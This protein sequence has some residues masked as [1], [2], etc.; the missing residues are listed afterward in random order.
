MLRDILIG[1]TVRIPF[2]P[3]ALPWPNIFIPALL[4]GI[5]R[6]SRFS[7]SLSGYPT[8][9]SL[10]PPAPRPPSTPNATPKMPMK[11]FSKNLNGARKCQGSKNPRRNRWHPHTL[12][13]PDFGP[14]IKLPVTVT[15]KGESK[16]R[17]GA[18]TSPP[19]E[20]FL[21]SVIHSRNYHWSLY[22]HTKLGEHDDERGTATKT[23]RKM[24]TRLRL[25]AEFNNHPRRLF[26]H[27]T[28]SEPAQYPIPNSSPTSVPKPPQAATSFTKFIRKAAL[29]ESPL[30]PTKPLVR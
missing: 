20:V 4:D 7:K 26:S 27:S 8:I 2:L 21:L 19:P 30:I 16:R 10:I 5:Q 12:E 11:T 22:Q 13:L 17:R 24:D 18:E 28:N 1:L 25:P 23:P 9:V 14:K 6:P 29:I 3:D 15:V